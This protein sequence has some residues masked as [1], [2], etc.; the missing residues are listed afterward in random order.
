MFA[1]SR[2]TIEEKEELKKELDLL[3]EV[4]TKTSNR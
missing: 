2:M 4:D 3:K 1:D